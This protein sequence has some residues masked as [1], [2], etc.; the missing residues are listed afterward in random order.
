MGHLNVQF[1]MSHAE[2]GFSWLAHRLFSAAGLVAGPALGRAES[3]HVKFQRE[4]RAGAA[5]VFRG[6]VLSLTAAHLELYGEMRRLVD[7]DLCATFVASYRL[8]E[9]AVVHAVPERLAEFSTERSEAARPRG[10]DMAPP[11]E[12]ISLAEAQELGLVR[13]FLGE[14]PA[15][16]YGADRRLT[17]AGFMAVLS[18]GIPAL[19]QDLRGEDRSQADGIGG[20]ALE[21]RFVFRR[22]ALSGQRLE[23]RSGLRAQGRKTRNFCHW[24]LDADTG[25]GLASAEAVAVTLDLVERR[26]VAVDDATRAELEKRIVPGLGP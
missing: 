12:E 4:L 17:A 22:P 18:E 16:H 5:Y 14:A 2:S 26:A 23:V 3:Y 7:D 6:G 25:E 11:R 19:V 21:Y 8:P 9:G 13:I 1:Y 20:A 15:I 24:V 10:I